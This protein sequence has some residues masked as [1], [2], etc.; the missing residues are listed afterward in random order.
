MR[1]YH[2]VTVASASLTGLPAN[3][4]DFDLPIAEYPP[5]LLPASLPLREAEESEEEFST[6]LAAELEELILREGPDTVAAF[7][8]EPVMGAGG[9]IMPPAGYF[10]EDPGGAR[11]ARRAVHRR[12]GDLRLRP[13][14]HAGSARETLGMP[15]GYDVLRQGVDLRLP[16]ARRRDDP[17]ADVR[18]HARREPQDRHLRPRL[19]LFGPPGLLRGRRTRP[20]RS[21]SATGSSRVAAKAPQF[22]RRLAALAEHPLVGEARG[23]G[24][25]GGLEIVAEQAHQA[26]VRRRRRASAAKARRLRAGRGPDRALADGRPHRG[27][28]AARH[29][30]E[31]EI[32]EL[33]DRLTRALDRTADWITS[34]GLKAA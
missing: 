7:I 22:Q 1:G 2:G 16:A 12:R 29:R 27:L 20:S 6:R 14:R 8:A 26:L 9:A 33:F 32:D 21:T 3:H 15:P 28:P 25:I 19:H 34:E 30:S 23:I 17:G 31:D 10:A 18:G 11:Q 24:L 5:R 13:A 4:T